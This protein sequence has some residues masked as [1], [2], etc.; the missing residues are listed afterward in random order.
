MQPPNSR[1]HNITREPA[2]N[3][4]HESHIGKKFHIARV[5][6][7]VAPFATA[8]APAA[9]MGPPNAASAS[10][11]NVSGRLMGTG[12]TCGARVWCVRFNYANSRLCN[13]PLGPWEGRM[14]HAAVAVVS[15]PACQI[16]KHRTRA[17]GACTNRRSALTHRAR[18]PRGIPT[19][20]R[21]LQVPP[22]FKCE[23]EHWRTSLGAASRRWLKVASASAHCMAQ[24]P[25]SLI[26]QPFSVSPR[27]AKRPGQSI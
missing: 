21:K 16:Y 20:G 27:R 8:A 19:G 9:T 17:R 7:P 15:S 1:T 14:C 23:H 25:H 3:R 5:R 18:A 22:V 26:V 11:T 10:A 6:V 2:P 12:F 4:H 13:K 24:G